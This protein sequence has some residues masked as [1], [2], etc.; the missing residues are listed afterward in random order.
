M[1]LEMQGDAGRFVRMVR[2]LGAVMA[3]L[4][5]GV[6]EQQMGLARFRQVVEGCFGGHVRP[7]WFTCGVWVGVV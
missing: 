1:H 3:P 7:W 2:T 5:R 4:K 6:A